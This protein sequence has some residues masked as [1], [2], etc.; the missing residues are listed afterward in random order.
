MEFRRILS[1]VGEKWCIGGD[2]NTIMFNEE[3]IGIGS[4][5][6]SRDSTYFYNFMEVMELVNLLRIGGR[7][8]WF[9]GNGKSMSRLDRFLISDKLILAKKFVSQIVGKR[10]LFDHYRVWMK[11]GDSDRGPKPF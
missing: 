1:S 8:T 3:R 9:N 6:N 5:I 10:C 7:F 2:F 4:G 11:A